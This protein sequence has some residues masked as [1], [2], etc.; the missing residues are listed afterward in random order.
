M[1][2]VKQLFLSVV[3]LLSLLAGTGN[4]ADKAN[5]GPASSGPGYLVADLQQILREAS[6]VRALQVE[7]EQRRRALQIRIREQ[8]EALR[9]D[10]KRLI[11]RRSSLTNEAFAAERA[12]FEERV[13]AV[14][15][16]IQASKL[17][18]DRLYT[19]AMA[20]IQES[21]IVIVRQIAEERSA[22]LVLSKSTVVIV[23]PTLEITDEALRRL[24]KSLPA[25][26]LPEENKGGN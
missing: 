4:A 20:G 11:E 25:V 22:D 14:Q 21:L 6:A 19:N 15:K 10:E 24:N 8:E 2:R 26:T 13:A 5:S 23:R 16:D 18:L 17:N 12:A 1:N 3:I 9:D 7:V